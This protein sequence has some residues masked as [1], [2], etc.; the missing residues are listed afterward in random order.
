M[1]LLDIHLVEQKHIEESYFQDYAKVHERVERILE[2]HQRPLSLQDAEAAASMMLALLSGQAEKNVPPE[3]LTHFLRCALGH[4]CVELSASPDLAPE[5]IAARA[6]E[7][8]KARNWIDA[9]FDA[10]AAAAEAKR[11]GLDEKKV[12]AKA[13]SSTN[14]PGKTTVATGISRKEDRA[15][16]NIDEPGKANVAPEQQADATKTP[17]VEA[18]T[19]K[20][21]V[22]KAPAKK[23]VAAKPA[24]TAKAKKPAAAKPKA[25][26]K[27]VAAKPKAVKKAAAAKPK[28]EKKP[29]AKKAAAKKAPAKKAAP[30]KKA[31][32]AKKVAEKKVAVKKAAPAKKPVA[33]K[34]AAPKAAAKKV[35]AKKPVAKKAA[36]AKKAAE[37]KVVAK[38]AAPAKKPVAKKAPAKK[39]VAKK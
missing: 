21:A 11:L 37:K 39:A 18:S 19:E 28:A 38:K 13:S 35:P 17:A 14:A 15:M 25:E 16:S 1:Q 8:M 20:K 2:K 36:P 33:K 24:A 32:P 6:Y 34:A 10:A 26:K 12:H 4:I 30:V 27:V 22:R 23:A 3:R 7:E 29:V 5:A 31:A 9:V